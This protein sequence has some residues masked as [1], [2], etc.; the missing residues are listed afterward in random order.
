MGNEQPE[1]TA[2]PESDSDDF[3]AELARLMDERGVGMRELT[4]RTHYEPG[5]I[6]ELRSGRKP[7]TPETARVLD[8]ALAAGGQLIEAQRKSGII[9][10]LMF[11]ITARPWSRSAP[12]GRNR[13][14]DGSAGP[15]RIH[16]P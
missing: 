4:R 11:A 1:S 13:R 8:S 2:D 14:R 3:S 9:R 10:A 12:P 16:C 7:S 6:S 5:H 15:A